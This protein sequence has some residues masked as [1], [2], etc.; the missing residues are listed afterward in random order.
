VPGRIIMHSFISWFAAL[1]DK[2]Q[3]RLRITAFAYIDY[4]VMVLLLLGY[5]MAGIISFG[6]PFK[7]FTLAL[8]MNAL[9]LLAIGSGWSKRLR[10]PSL[11]WLQV[12]AACGVDLLGIALAPHIAYVFIINLFVPLSYGSLN[13]NDRM[14]VVVWMFVVAGLGALLST[15][16]VAELAITTPLE[17]VFFW[18]AI[19]VTFGRFLMVTA[20]VSRLRLRLQGRN[21]ELA[22]ATHKLVD[23]SSRD[24][25]TGLW[26]RREFM[27]LLQEESR[28]A[29]RSRLSFSVALID[30]DHFKQINEQFGHLVSDAVL[31][32]MAQLL[33]ASRRAT[34]SVGRYG[35]DQFTLLLVQAKRS[36]AVVALERTRNRVVQHDWVNIAPGLKLTVSAGIAEWQPGETLM[37]VL[38]RADM[39]LREAKRSGRNCVHVSEPVEQEPVID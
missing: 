5:A 30:I 16:G 32:E 23:L 26:N 13:F 36:T 18:L 11:T 25:L 1:D 39:A 28:R 29:I 27:R 31:H 15:L 37:Q 17:K 22:A 4:V 9:F 33:E 2:T 12:F 8:C 10:D 24:E 20:E 19:M 14:F 35:G 6:V 7:I 21:R 34:D 3:L 38:N